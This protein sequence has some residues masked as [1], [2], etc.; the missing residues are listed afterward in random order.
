MTTLTTYY[1]TCSAAEK[2][3]KPSLLILRMRGDGEQQEHDGV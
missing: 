1:G 3:E 2:A